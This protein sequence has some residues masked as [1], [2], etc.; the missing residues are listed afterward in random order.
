MVDR[1]LAPSVGS[2][3]ADSAEGGPIRIAQVSGQVVMAW[4]TARSSG[5]VGLFRLACRTVPNPLLDGGT[6]VLR[7]ETIAG[8]CRSAIKSARIGLAAVVMLMIFVTLVT[9]CW[10]LT[11]ADGQL[12]MEKEVRAGFVCSPETPKSPHKRN[13]PPVP[14]RKG[15]AGPDKGA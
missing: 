1:T 13:G 12:L 4:S 15:A 11:V 3:W 8:R 2:L 5:P 7:N 14:I 6:F 10:H 9:S